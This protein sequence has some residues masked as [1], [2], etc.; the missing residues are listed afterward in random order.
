MEYCLGPNASCYFEFLH[1]SL[2]KP[3]GFGSPI[4]EPD[5]DLGLGQRQGRGELSSLGDGQVLLLTELSLQGQKLCGGEGSA[6]LAVGFVLP[7]RA[8]CWTELPYRTWDR[9]EAE[10]S[11]SFIYS[12]T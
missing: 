4:L 5:L 7:Q 6:R 9:C 1:L 12:S 11:P 10:S 8:H 2:L 3:L